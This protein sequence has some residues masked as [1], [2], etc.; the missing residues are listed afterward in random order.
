MKSTTSTNIMRLYFTK[1]ESLFSEAA[2]ATSNTKKMN[3]ERICANIPMLH[4]VSGMYNV[5]E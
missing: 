1:G 2:L 3:M 5:I 4:I